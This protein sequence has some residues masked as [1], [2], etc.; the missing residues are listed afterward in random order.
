MAKKMIQ[1]HGGMD[2]GEL[3]SLGIDPAS[4]IDFSVNI[5]PFGPTPSVLTALRSYDPS[6]Y[7]DRE[8]SELRSRLAELNSCEVE[9]ILTGNGTADLIWLIAWTFLQ[10][11]KVLILAPTFGE[12][13]RAA[14][15]VGAQ[16]NILWS[17]KDNFEFDMQRILNEI[18]QFHPAA[19]FLCNPNNPSGSWLESEDV[20]SIVEACEPGILILDEAYRSFVT[21]NPFA[22][23]PAKN[24]LILR[25]MTKDFALAGLRLGYLLGEAR[26]IATLRANQPTWNVN[27]AAQLAGLAA[28]DDLPAVIRDLEK[29]HRAAHELNSY[30]EESGWR[31]VPSSTQ[32]R[33]VD[34]S[35]Q[36]APDFRN[37]LLV[38]GIQVRDCTSFGLPYFVR[39]G[40]R[41][42]EENNK[43]IEE[44]GKRR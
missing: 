8:V 10:Q 42:P 43:L 25:S 12:Y 5:N 40:T 21:L 29:T 33:L 39:I 19:T 3:H 7:P 14:R 15:A 4:I 34:V 11:Q 9:Q 1:E 22:P 32:F 30:F 23:L 13:G 37:D 36:S 44:L 28:L 24:V 17:V 6:V 41:T 26:Q 20:H 31:M 18:D 27:G 38:R 2:I 35:P 16:V